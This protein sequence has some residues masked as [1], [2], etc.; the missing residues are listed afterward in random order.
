VTGL[1]PGSGPPDVEMTTRKKRRRKHKKRAQEP[2]WDTLAASVA[3]IT[4]RACGT[5][6][7]VRDIIGDEPGTPVINMLG[8]IAATSLELSLGHDK[9]MSLL[10][11]LGQMAL[12]EN[13]PEAR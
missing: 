7:Q 12:E 10:R 5:G 1:P 3:I 8:L 4:A 6:D 13:T 9:T 2:S 11:Q